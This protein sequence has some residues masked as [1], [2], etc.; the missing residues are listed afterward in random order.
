VGAL[1]M[2]NFHGMA[3][4]PERFRAR[5]LYRHNDNVTLMRTTPEECREL[6]REIG[7]RLAAARGPAEILFPLR[8]VSAYDAPGQPFED[9][10][11]RAALLEGLRERRG[12]VPLRELDLHLN[13]AAFA[14]TPTSP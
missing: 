14:R 2:V 8:G 3:T 5:K 13:D 11:A 10:A 4:V 1:D 12:G 7:S 9:A 6:G